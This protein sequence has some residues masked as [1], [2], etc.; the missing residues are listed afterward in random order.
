MKN[1]FFRKILILFAIMNLYTLVLADEFNFDVTEIQ[2]SDNGNVIKGI[3]GGTVTAENNIIIT[4][5]KFEYNKL[6]S[7]LKAIGNAKLVDQNENITIES[8]EVYYL[9]DKEEIYTLGES[10]ANNGLNIKI[11]SDEYFKYNKLTSLLEAKGNVIVL[12]KKKDILIESNEIFY[13]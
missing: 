2:I 6:T 11:N 7:L 9:K 3:K 4:A 12:D 13:L 10:E 1:S 5:D 8:N